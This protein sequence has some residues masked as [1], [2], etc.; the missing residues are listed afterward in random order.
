MNEL[1]IGIG[2][3]TNDASLANPDDYYIGIVKDNADPERI[4]RCRVWSSRIYAPDFPTEDIPW[5]FPR[6]PVFFGGDG[7]AGSVSI[8]KKGSVVKLTFENDDPQS[9]EYHHMMGL[10]DDVR[11][12]L[13]EEYDGVHIWGMDSDEDFKLYFTPKTGFHIYYGDS[14]VNIAPDNAITV[15]HAGSQSLIEMRGGVITTNADSEIN[16][17]AGS[18]IHDVSQECWYDGK[19]TKVGHNPNYSAVL[20]EPLKTLLSVMAAAID[21]K[22]P[23]TPNV[24]KSNVDKMAKTFMSNTV[25][26]SR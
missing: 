9:P 8:P 21:M 24:V 18:R 1:P 3:H 10:A 15:H 11:N 16:T 26:V 5:A 20:A 23:S 19:V 14:F 17:T 4:G 13:G 22:L 7:K 2:K 12:F 25:K 6:Y